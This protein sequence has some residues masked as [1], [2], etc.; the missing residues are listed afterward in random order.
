MYL[1]KTFD[2][3]A[4][5]V[6]ATVPHR[7]HVLAF[8]SLRNVRRYVFAHMHEHECAWIVSYLLFCR[9]HWWGLSAIVF[10]S[11]N[12]GTFGSNAGME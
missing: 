3:V 6:A 12:Q 7:A 4:H 5:G 8:G 10:S 2:G 11:G 9:C 1:S